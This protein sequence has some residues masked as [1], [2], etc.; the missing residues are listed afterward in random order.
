MS[1]M[2][3]SRVSWSTSCLPY[4]DVGERW[5][6]CILR[7]KNIITHL[8]R[9]LLKENLPFAG[10]VLHVMMGLRW[11]GLV[12]FGQHWPYIS[13]SD[14]LQLFSEAH[15]DPLSQGKGCVVG[16]KGF[17]E[18][19]AGLCQVSCWFIIFQNQP[20]YSF[21]TL[22]IGTNCC[23]KHLNTWINC[24][25]TDF[26]TNAESSYCNQYCWGHFVHDY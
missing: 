22:K 1:P 23:S 19:A 8:T 7:S 18:V 26:K 4:T 24:T 3:V 10:F 9:I 2:V 5:G 12:L 17:N 21:F 6:T 13:N 11:Q 16:Q 14:P 25:M 20:T 15:L